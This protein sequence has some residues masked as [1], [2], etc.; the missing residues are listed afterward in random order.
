MQISLKAWSD[1]ELLTNLILSAN[2]HSAEVSVSQRQGESNIRQ[3]CQIYE[4]VSDTT[5]TKSKALGDITLICGN[6]NFHVGKNVCKGAFEFLKLLN[7][8]LI[9]IS[10]GK[11]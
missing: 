9:S 3:Q 4:Y 5:K 11:E 8:C 7:F 10:I 2:V 1:S 6:K